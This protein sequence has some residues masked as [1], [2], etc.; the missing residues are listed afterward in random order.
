MLAYH[1][2]GGLGVE[3]HGDTE[4]NALNPLEVFRLGECR[5]VAHTWNTNGCHKTPGWEKDSP[6]SEPQQ[7]K[8]AAG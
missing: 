8:A 7:P 4:Q 5:V 3:R 1:C 6:M 2:Q